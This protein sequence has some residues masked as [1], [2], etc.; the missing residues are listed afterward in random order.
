MYAPLLSVCFM[1]VFK[2]ARSEGFD[3]DRGLDLAHD[4]LQKPPRSAA[5]HNTTHGLAQQH[6]RQSLVHA[7]ANSQLNWLLPLFE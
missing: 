5:E 2:V 3:P 4:V 7:A 1:L 6:N